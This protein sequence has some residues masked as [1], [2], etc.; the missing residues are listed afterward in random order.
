M[1]IQIKNSS[2]L[3]SKTVIY[4]DLEFDLAPQKVGNLNTNPTWVRYLDKWDI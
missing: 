3:E 4:I 1:Y 2:I